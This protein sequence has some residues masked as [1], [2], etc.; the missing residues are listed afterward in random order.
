VNLL[1]FFT[2]TQMTTPRK[3]ALKRQL[4]KLRSDS[5]ALFLDVVGKAEIPVHPQPSTST[6]KL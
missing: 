6:L 2:V 3:Q 1:G 5:M 4:G